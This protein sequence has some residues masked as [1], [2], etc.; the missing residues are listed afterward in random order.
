MT[1]GEGGNRGHTV[2][3]DVGA[4]EAEQDVAHA[5]AGSH[6]R[7]GVEPAHAHALVRRLRTHARGFQAREPACDAP[8]PAL[9]F[10]S[11]ELWS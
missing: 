5:H 1:G 10:Q 8:V 9:D 3:A 2:V 7:G 4:V 11:S 6:G